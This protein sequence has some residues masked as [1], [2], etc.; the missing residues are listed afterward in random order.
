[1]NI[2]PEENTSEICW[3]VGATYGNDDQS[4]RFLQEGIWENGYSDKYLEL[5]KSAR[6]GE[7][8]AIKASYT[9][10]HGLPFDNRGKSV[11][12]MAIKAIGVITENP[13]DGRTLKVRW[14]AVNPPR[15]WYFYTVM[16]MIWRV[17]P[18]EWEK[19]ALIDF[20]FSGKTQDIDRFRN[21]PYWRDRFGDKAAAQTR[22]KWTNFYEAIAD[23]LLAFRHRREE[24]IAA[25]HAIAAKAKGMSHLQD[26]FKDGSKG[27]LKDICPFTV[28]GIFNRK[29]TDENRKEIAAELAQFLGVTE[30]IP[31]T[32]DGVP[33]L[34]NQNSWFFA[35]DEHRNPDDIDTLWEVFA[36][37]LAFA[38]N[39]DD[40]SRLALMAAYDKAITRKNVKWNLS[41]GLFWARPWFFPTLDGQSRLYID[42]VLD[43]QIDMDTA[44]HC[45][46]A[47]NYLTLLDALRNHFQEDT[48][49]V[50]SFPELSLAAWN[51]VGDTNDDNDATAKAAAETAQARTYT[52]DD[53]ITDGC[54]LEIATIRQ[55]RDQLQR[56]KNIILQ[57]PPGTGKTWLAKRLA[58]A[59]MGQEAKERIRA[60]QFHPNLSY[61]DFIRG[62]RPVGDKEG[63]GTLQLVD[64]PFLEM[65]NIAK[66]KENANNKYVVVI[67]EI[68]RGNPARI[69]GE[70]LTLLEADKRTPDEA[71]E[72][73]YR[74]TDDERVYIPANLYVIGTMN[75]ADRSLALVD[76]AL[77]R[78]FAFINLQPVLGDKWCNWVHTKCR[79]DTELLSVIEQR[80]LQLN[81]TI[82]N[83]K[84]LGA[85]F[86]IGH[87]YITPPRNANID[88]G[89]E[90]FRHV[91]TNEIVPLLEEYW[92]DAP[93]KIEAVKIALLE[94]F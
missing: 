40:E 16:K 8:I 50:H 54:F 11:S 10:K 67:E 35:Y 4:P 70:M 93:D 34:N 81:E 12:I 6:P 53:I 69:F 42:K 88:N 29:L 94:G 82:K 89:K 57:G 73:T 46:S 77:R 13:G 20:T 9:R 33:L 60:V 27:P 25:I 68:N 58:Y 48:Y 19:E 45:C 85:Q 62:W 91:V 23:K 38:D 86:Q 78:R 21:A 36:C 76:L 32:F 17:S 26:N 22:F 43:M 63:K 92:F 84:N 44:K 72:L 59:L 41:M 47:A 5:V 14:E 74:R 37:A 49:P 80:I 66:K 79:I 75:I 87:S 56:K 3:F 24:L 18:D 64:G 51:F 83:D 55:I 61:E 7:R 30:D 90:W 15:E 28:M 39:D 31:I 2:H 71:L 1:M 52:I 65:I